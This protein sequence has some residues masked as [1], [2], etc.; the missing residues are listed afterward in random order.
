VACG[1]QRNHSSDECSHCGSEF[2]ADA[3]YTVSTQEGR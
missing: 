1:R 2:V 3:T